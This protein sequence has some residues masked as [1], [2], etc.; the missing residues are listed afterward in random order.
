LI[1]A[2]TVGVKAATTGAP[3]S[4]DTPGS[5]G[6]SKSLPLESLLTVAWSERV[7]YPIEKLS[8]Y[9]KNYFS[10]PNQLFIEMAV[11][12]RIWWSVPV[13]DR[14]NVTG[15]SDVASVSAGQ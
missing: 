9:K 2:L 7:C 5:G 11:V 3:L 1:Q 6:M 10:I 12:I 8:K 4:G 15:N 13:W 14:V